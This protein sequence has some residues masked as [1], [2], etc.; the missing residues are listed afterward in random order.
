MTRERTQ[1]DDHLEEMLANALS[2]TPERGM[3]AKNPRYRTIADRLL[4]EFGPGDNA[5]LRRELFDRC[6]RECQNHGEAAYKIVV[7][8]VRSA[9][10][11]DNPG[12]Y[13][14]ATVARRMREAGFFAEERVDF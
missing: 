2:D 9:R 13:F 8:A 5:T 6:Q 11:A 14:S 10:T 1:A 7:G 3:G 12:R 4:K